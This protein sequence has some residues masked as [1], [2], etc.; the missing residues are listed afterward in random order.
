[1]TD[2]RYPESA[3]CHEA[4]HVVV[5]A[6]QGLRLSRHGIHLDADGRGISYYQYRKPKRFSAQPSEIS[7]EHT[8][9]ATLAG[10]IAQQKFYPDCSVCGA[11][12][13]QSFIDML[14]KEIEE[15]DDFIGTAVLRAQLDLP[16]EATRLVELHWLAIDAVARA[17]WD[18]P[19]TPRNFHEPEPQWSE[20]KMEKWLPGARIVEILR[21]FGIEASIWDETILAD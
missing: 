2:P 12:D 3:A 8:I 15:E 13:D 19:I 1:M 4:G 5:A 17:L 20:S 10:L 11:S 18:S 6:A 9:I 14:T 21:R 7:R 16:R